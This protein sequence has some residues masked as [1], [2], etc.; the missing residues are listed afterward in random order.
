M[1][2]QIVLLLQI[3]I[4]NYNFNSDNMTGKFKFKEYCPLVFKNLRERFGV[5]DDVFNQTLSSCEPYYEVS[6]TFMS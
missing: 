6:G 1:I 5:K 4:E 2:C 3:S